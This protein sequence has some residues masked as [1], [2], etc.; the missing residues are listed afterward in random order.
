MGNYLLLRKKTECPQCRCRRSF[1]QGFC[2]NCGIRLFI[3]PINFRAFEDDGNERRYWL[4]TN[5][6]GWIHRDQVIE[7]FQAQESRVQFSAVTPNTKSVRERISEVRK[8][9]T[10]RIKEISPKLNRFGY[11]KSKTRL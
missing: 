11:G 1:T 6:K 10:K 9:T 3:R 8:D 4:W 5:D 2:H 7:G